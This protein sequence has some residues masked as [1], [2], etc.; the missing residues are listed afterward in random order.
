MSVFLVF[1][2]PKKGIV[3]GRIIYF[4]PELLKA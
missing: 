1:Q 2:I 3:T 4:R